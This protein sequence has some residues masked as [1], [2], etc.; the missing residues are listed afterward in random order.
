VASGSFGIGKGGLDGQAMIF[1]AAVGIPLAWG[2]WVT[3]VN[4][5]KMF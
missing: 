2:V 1:W 4:A 5:A 3:L